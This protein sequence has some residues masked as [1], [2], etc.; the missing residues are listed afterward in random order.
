MPFKKYFPRKK[1]RYCFYAAVLL[2]V[3]F[4]LG[5]LMCTALIKF[6]SPPQYSLLYTNYTF[7]KELSKVIFQVEDGA[8]KILHNQN[9]SATT[10]E[11]Y[12]QIFFFNANNNKIEHYSIGIATIGNRVNYFINGLTENYKVINNE[13]SPDGYKFICNRFYRFKEAIHGSHKHGSCVIKRGFNTI[14]L[15]T[16][17]KNGNSTTY[18]I[19]WI[20]NG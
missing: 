16:K 6:E 12:P 4:F 2:P 10:E 3:V 17:A 8:L 9:S 15:T 14:P 18:F 13:L 19:G 11:N 5:N 20:K 1:E 7:D